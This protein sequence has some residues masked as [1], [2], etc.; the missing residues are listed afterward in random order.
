[1]ATENWFHN[2]LV[3]RHMAL[4]TQDVMDAAAFNFQG[5]LRFHYDREPEEQHLESP[6]EV[7]WDIWWSASCTGNR[8]VGDWF[9]L[10][11]QFE[12]TCPN[13]QYRLDYSIEL[14]DFSTFETLRA[15]GLRWPLIGVE[16][17]GHA[18]HEK[19][20]EQVTYRN[21]RDR[22]L[23]QA[24]WKIFHYS[25]SEMNDKAIDCISEVFCFCRDMRQALLSEAYKR[26]QTDKQQGEI[27][28]VIESAS[29][30]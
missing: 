4:A 14:A 22:A 30:G 5:G 19:T 9:D 10:I 28:H 1:M 11:P 20:L 18:F 24:G 2:E 29:K 13:Q 21:Q 15:V 17:D 25:F 8:T 6:L 7:I 16:L 27:S 23:Q 26:R 3:R 12:V